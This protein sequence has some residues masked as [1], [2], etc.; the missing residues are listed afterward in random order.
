MPRRPAVLLTPPR[1]I[2]DSS[3]ACP[4]LRRV[5]SPYTSFAYKNEAH[6]LSPQPLPH[7]YTKTPGCQGLYLQT[8]SRKMCHPQRFSN[9]ADFALF[10]DHETHST[11]HVAL[12][13]LSA[14]LTAD[15]R[16]LPCFGRSCPPATPLGA[17]LTDFAPVT[18]LSATLTKNKGGG[19]PSLR[20]LAPIPVVELTTLY[21][22]ARA[23]YVTV[24]LG[25]FPVAV[26]PT[27]L[28]RNERCDLEENLGN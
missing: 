9:S 3:L 13:P 5:H 4:E 15:L 7:S 2:P 25:V 8:L 23:K 24:N 14:T 19:M 28:L 12:T 11:E 20:R 22:G 21:S 10:T 27:I 18:P 17:T 1:Y 16:V 26:L 6:P